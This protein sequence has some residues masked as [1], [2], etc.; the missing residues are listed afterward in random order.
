MKLAILGQLDL[1]D[2]TIDRLEALTGEPLAVYEAAS[3]EADVLAG[4]E[5]AD[6]ALVTWRTP[7]TA[8][9]MKANPS[10]RYIGMAAS[11]YTRR[12]ASPI[13][14]DA[15]DASGVVVTSLGQYGDEGV[16]EWVLTRA[17]SASQTITKWRNDKLELAGKQMGVVGYGWVGSYVA[18]LATAFGMDVIYSGPRQK[19]EAEERGRRYVQ[20]NELLAT[21]DVVTLH[22]PKGVQVMHA[23]EF[24]VL[25]KDALLVNTSIGETLD[26]QALAKWLENDEAAFACDACVAPGQRALANRANVVFD[27]FVAGDSVEMRQ[28]KSDQLVENLSAFIQGSP[29]RVVAGHTPGHG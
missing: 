6:A 17:L 22:V 26:V 27:D 29:I 7:V 19:P 13:D 5:G 18:R 1:V 12:D 21:S 20:L 14:L 24:D 2:G 28:R 8:E 25:G 15:A 10:L 11:A 9:A 4:L 23:G 3:D 16:A